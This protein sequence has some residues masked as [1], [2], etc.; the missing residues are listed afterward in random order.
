MH[1]SPY[2]QAAGPNIVVD[3]S[4]NANT[5]ITL[6]HWPKSGTPRELKADTSAEI[7]F[8]YLDSPKFHVRSDIVTNNHFDQDGLIGIFVLVDPMTANRHRDLLIDV[9]S[10]G[11]F[12]V[13][14]SRAAA[15]INFAVSSL[16]DSQTSPFSNRIF[17]LP[18]PEMAAELYIRM[19]DLF[20]QIVAEPDNFK[21]LWESEDAKLTESENMVKAGRIIIEECPDLDFAVVQLPDRLSASRVHRFTMPQAD[22]CHP[23]AIYNATPC[24]RILLTQ[25]QHVEFQYRYEGWVQLVSRRPLARIDL[26]ALAEEL[27]AEENSGGKW[28]FDGV[29]E[30]TPRLHLNGKHETSI[31]AEVVRRRIEQYLKT[32]PPA[33]DPYDS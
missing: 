30:I 20:P 17:T 24:S 31:P 21:S 5:L 9:A 25:G 11:D 2:D 26:S 27:N 13:F 7:T 4:Q 14:R 3:G 18:Y 29:E 23:L 15:R 16:A 6:S 8:K 10:A 28:E 32:A 12:G 1:F 19:L 22:A 33:W